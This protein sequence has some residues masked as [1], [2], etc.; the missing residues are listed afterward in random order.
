MV[1][2]Y[3]LID[4]ELISH[5]DA[6]DDFEEDRVWQCKMCYFEQPKKQR[7]VD[8]LEVDNSYW[9]EYADGS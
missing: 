8:S 3:C 6:I 5:L 2:H 4:M 1:C 7:I 9:E